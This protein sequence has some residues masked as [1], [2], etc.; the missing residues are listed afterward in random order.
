[1]RDVTRCLPERPSRKHLQAKGRANLLW[2]PGSQPPDF[3]LTVDGQRFAVEVTQVMESLELGGLSITSRGAIDALQRAVAELRSAAKKVDLLRG[4]YHIHVCA[5]PNLRACLPQIQG[6]VFHYLTETANR[7]TAEPER[8]Y[9]GK[10]DRH[11]TIR[12]LH[13]VGGDL[14]ESMSIGDA[15]WQA[16]IREELTQLLASAISIKASKPVN[17]SCARILLLVDAYHCGEADDWRR[18]ALPASAASFHTIARVYHDHAC[19][20]LTSMNGGWR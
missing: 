19:Q 15:S 2:E 10:R 8:I 20:V 14:V 7:R 3:F 11:W 12:K 18:T 13:D 6:R 5:I 17:V 4:F 16:E 9:D 1:M